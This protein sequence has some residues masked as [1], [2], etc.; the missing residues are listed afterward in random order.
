M[1][2]GE[3]VLHHIFEIETNIYIYIYIYIYTYTYTYISGI[4]AKLCRALPASLE[5]VSFSE[6]LTP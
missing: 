4:G 3:Q 2:Q 6:F 1:T 5:L